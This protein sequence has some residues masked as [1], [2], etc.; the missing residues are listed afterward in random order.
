VLATGGHFVFL[1][2]CTPEGVRVTATV[3]FDICDRNARTDR[4]ALHQQ[5]ADRAVAFFDRA[6]GAT[7]AR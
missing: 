1:P 7:Q 2:V 5:V 6:L 3:A 4:A